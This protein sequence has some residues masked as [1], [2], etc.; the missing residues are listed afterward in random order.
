MKLLHSLLD[1]LH[2]CLAFFFSWLNPVSLSFSW[3]DL[4]VCWCG[5]NIVQLLMMTSQLF[6]LCSCWN[7]FSF[8]WKFHKLAGQ[9]P[10]CFLAAAAAFPQ[11]TI[12]SDA[13]N[14]ICDQAELIGWATNGGDTV[15]GCEILQQLR[16]VVNIPLFVGLNNYPIGGAWFCKHPQ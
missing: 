7:P 15:D 11:G 6:H 2:C 13:K 4:H 14:L 9:L 10:H 16:D 8:R 1:K 12:P 5:S 3:L